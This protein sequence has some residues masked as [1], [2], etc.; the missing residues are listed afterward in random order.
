MS[1]NSW[2]ELFGGSSSNPKD[3]RCAWFLD[4]K[5]SLGR[6]GLILELR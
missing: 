2:M 4:E 5:E 6:L 3:G 1:L